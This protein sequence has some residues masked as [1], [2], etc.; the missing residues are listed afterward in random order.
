VNG[1]DYGTTVRLRLTISPGTVGVNAFHASVI[2]YDT[3]ASVDAS[4]VRLTFSQP[5][6]PDLGSSTLRLERQTDGTFAGSGANLSLIGEWQIAALISEP[7]RSVEV[8]LALTVQSSRQQ[9]DVNREAGLP[10]IY[11]VHLGSGRTVQ[12]YLD[13]GTPG[14]NL[15]HATWFDQSGH[16]MPVSDVTM[17]ELLPSGQSVDLLPQILDSGHEAAPVQVAGLPASFDIG[18]VGPGGAALQVQLQ[19]AQSS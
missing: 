12:I 4:A 1:S 2:D 11:T 15:L 8:D 10:T 3:R 14:P 17:T 16:E 7:T 5:A 19:I 9:V 6:R 13:P 18:A